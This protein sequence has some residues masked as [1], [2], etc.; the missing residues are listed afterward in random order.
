MEKKVFALSYG[1]DVKWLSKNKVK[2]RGSFIENYYSYT[3]LEISDIMLKNINSK[4]YLHFTLENKTN[5]NRL[6]YKDSKQKLKLHIKINDCEYKH[7]F[8]EISEKNKILKN[9][10]IKY[11]LL[12]DKQYKNKVKINLTLASNSLRILSIN[13]KISLKDVNN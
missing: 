12:I 11:K 3:G 13:K 9:E 8:F 10:K 1:N 2:H 6:F 4:T 7:Y 5:K